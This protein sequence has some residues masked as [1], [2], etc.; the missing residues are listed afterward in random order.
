MFWFCPCIFRPRWLSWTDVQVRFSSL[1]FALEYEDCAN[2]TSCTDMPVDAYYPVPLPVTNLSTVWSSKVAT[3]ALTNSLGCGFGNSTRSWG[4]LSHYDCKSWVKFFEYTPVLPRRHV[5]KRHR[6]GTC[7]PPVCQSHDWHLCLAWGRCVCVCVSVVF[8]WD[9]WTFREMWTHVIHAHYED[10][11]L[12]FMLIVDILTKKRLIRWLFLYLLSKWFIQHVVFLRQSLSYAP[13]PENVCHIKYSLSWGLLCSCYN[14]STEDTLLRR[15]WIVKLQH[16]S[17]WSAG[18]SNLVIATETCPYLSTPALSRERRSMDGQQQQEGFAKLLLDSC[19]SI[20]HNAKHNY[21]NFFFPPLQREQRKI[22]A[23]IYA[24]TSSKC[25]VCK[26]GVIS[27]T[28]RRSVSCIHLLLPGG[29]REICYGL[30][31]WELLIRIETK[32]CVELD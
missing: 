30:L 32:P 6:L 9:V 20:P 23:L 8:L 2:Q 18:V 31:T 21:A 22:M 5:L 15:S 4:L 19:A 27:G 26:W 28:E 25:F 24:L 3:L 16:A 11:V 14:N 17:L 7:P 1:L 10:L 29:L 13:F 12:F